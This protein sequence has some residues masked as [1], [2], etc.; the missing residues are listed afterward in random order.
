MKRIAK[1]SLIT[2]LVLIGLT[3]VGAVLTMSFASMLPSDVTITTLGDTVSVSEIPSLGILAWVFALLAVWFAYF[4]AL[5]AVGFAMFV[6]AGILAFTAF[7]MLS[8][9]ILIGLIVWWFMRRKP[10]PPAPPAPT[11]DAPP[12]GAGA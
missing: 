12:A 6:T 11:I 7:V 4:V 8:P 1:F 5:C 10:A 9:F 2:F 3:F